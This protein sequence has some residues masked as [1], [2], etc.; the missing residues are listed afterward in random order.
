[1]RHRK[2]GVKKMAEKIGFTN[3]SIYYSKEDGWWIES[4]QLDSWIASDSS[5]IETKLKE[6]FNKGK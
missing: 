6:L 1:M 3:V 2:K 5:A 4:D